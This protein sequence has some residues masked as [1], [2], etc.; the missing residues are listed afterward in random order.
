LVDPRSLAVPY[1]DGSVG[2]LGLKA[3]SETVVRAPGTVEVG[4]DLG[5]CRRPFQIAAD[6]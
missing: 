5:S 4:A 2:D 6:C 1:R 3:V